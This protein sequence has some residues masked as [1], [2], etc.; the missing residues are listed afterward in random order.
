MV[1]STGDR[2]DYCFMSQ[3]LQDF[4]D[5]TW[6]CEGDPLPARVGAG[7]LNRGAANIRAALCG[8]AENHLRDWFAVDWS[9]PATKEIKGLDS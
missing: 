4:D 9:I 6:L 1:I 8:D 5:L 3:S 2:V 7:F